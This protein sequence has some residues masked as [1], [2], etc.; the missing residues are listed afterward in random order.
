MLHANFIEQFK[1]QDDTIEDG[2]YDDD[3]SEIEGNDCH[4]KIRRREERGKL[5]RAEKNRRARHR[6]TV[7]LQRQAQ[8][9]KAM[10]AEIARYSFCATL[11]FA[12]CISQFGVCGVC[13][14]V[15]QKLS[16]N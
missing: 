14:P 15:L 3:V 8:R 6:G 2:G 7:M 1:L 12:C 11:K 5:T 10:L 9:S 4:K 16:R 13:V